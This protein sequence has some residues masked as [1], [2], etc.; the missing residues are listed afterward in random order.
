MQPTDWEPLHCQDESFGIASSVKRPMLSRSVT[1]A[2][3]LCGFSATLGLGTAAR[4]QDPKPA[5]TDFSIS[6]RFDID[7]NTSRIDDRRSFGQVSAFFPLF[8]I[9][10]RH[11]TYLN[12][13]GRIDTSGDL[14]GSAAFGHRLAVDKDRV[15]GGYIA[16]DIR[17]SGAAT[18]NQIGLGA[19]VMGQTWTAHL[20]GYIPVGRTS[21]QVGG[22]T[23]GDRL[24]EAQFQGNQ[25]LLVTG[26]QQVVESALGSVEAGASF[27][28][29]NFGR[30]GNLWSLGS[31]YY[32]DN[33]LGGSLQL[34]HRVGDRFRVGLGAQ[35]DGVFGTQVLA[36]IGTSFGGVGRSAKGEG[37][38]RPWAKVVSARVNRNNNI[39]IR[40]EVRGTA[41]TSQVAVDPQTGE[42]YR[43]RHVTPDAEAANQGDGSAE[44][45]F[46]TLGSD[47][48][49]GENTG[50][51]GVEA[52]EIV[53]VRVGDSRES[54][55]APFTIPAGVQVYSEASLTALSTQ[56]GE[57]ALPGSGTGIRPLVRGGV[58]L[59][60]GNNRISG[61]EIDSAT[62]GIAIADP[63]GSIVVENNLVRNVA[64]RA[65]SITQSI[66]TANITISNNTI[67][68]AVN[69]GIRV[70]LTDTADLTLAIDNNQI[71]NIASADGDGIDIEANDSSQLAIALNNNR[72]DRAGNSGIEL[73]TCGNTT[74]DACNANFTATVTGNTINN[75]GG[76]GILFFH[77]SNQ[78]AQLAIANNRVAQSGVDQTGVTQNVGNPLPAPGNG[79]FGI[80]TVT[81][82]DGDLSLRIENNTVVDS[83]DE[84]IAVIN[85][86]QNNAASAT[87]AA[88]AVDA[89]IRGNT[90]SGEGVGAIASNDV[91]VIS[92]SQPGT[93]N[94]PL[95]CLELR[96]NEI[97]Q[98]IFLANGL[99]IAP[100]IN[101][102]VFTPGSFAQ[103][104]DSI[105]DNLISSG[106]LTFQSGPLAAF[107]TVPIV[108]AGAT[109]SDC[110][111]P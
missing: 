42:T 94:M 67:D 4:S 48:A 22:S 27:Q 6:P 73:E 31:A 24:V 75:S 8:Q 107:G 20:N 1:A 37:G 98:R 65:V 105:A 47:R 41:E 25:L 14:G 16:Y 38:D 34:E 12:T 32:I 92:G 82:A 83:Q 35:S 50:L 64:N 45:P 46:S 106:T 21:S 93:P 5:A 43:F 55:I 91:L 88:P 49:D 103:T 101:Q 111:L 26:G 74:A 85:N 7:L 89:A 63:I 97:E 44:S 104:A 72:I 39:A 28:L 70:E 17:D 23:S 13:V 10:G 87:T 84:K 95:V 30:Y 11:V 81:F 68:N 109:T 15:L 57:V 62:N 51:S 59:A 3:F 79:G 78:P 108:S 66:D 9:E 61:F 90:L 100:P 60:G 102:N 80:A 53:Y 69:D 33:S 52:G 29:G 71:N 58:A 76:D 2:L 96:E 18:F 19:E 77:N 110:S 54:A 99:A 40:Q 36:S 86:L 56:L